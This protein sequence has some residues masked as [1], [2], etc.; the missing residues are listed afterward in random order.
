MNKLLM[1]ISLFLVK[2]VVKSH[3][4]NSKLDDK[5]K[6]VTHQCWM[7]NLKS[8]KSVIYNYKIYWTIKLSQYQKVN[9]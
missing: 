1:N 2:V 8:L 3:D 6:N 5:T 9:L 4:K 7:W